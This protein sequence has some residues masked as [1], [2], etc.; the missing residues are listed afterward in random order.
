VTISLKLDGI[1]ISARMPTLRELS[2][3]ADAP[4]SPLAY[5]AVAK[6]CMLVPTLGE[7]AKR[8]PAAGI[9]IGAAILEAAGMLADAVELDESEIPHDVAESIVALEGKG[10]T[11]LQ[12]LRIDH[13]GVTRH[14]VQRMPTEREVDTYMKA[15]TAEA[16]KVL[17]DAV[18]TFPTKE[19]GGI[20]AIQQEAPAL[21]VV[22]A[23]FALRR[24]GL[25]DEA[26]LGE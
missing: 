9:S 18:T 16:A 26:I 15:E 25:L 6:A 1:E 2:S 5:K 21:Y 10:F 11:D 4:Q 13:G 19:M 12:A 17:A 24:A 8:K 14:F 3:V 7:L 23:K 20:T 22:L